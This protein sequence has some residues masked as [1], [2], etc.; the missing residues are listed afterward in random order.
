MKNRKLIASL[1]A[2]AAFLALVSLVITYYTTGIIEWLRLLTFMISG[3]L[4]YGVYQRK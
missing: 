4:A 3:L 1:F 2:V